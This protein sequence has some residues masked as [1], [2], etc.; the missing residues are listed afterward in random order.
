MRIAS[1]CW[2]LLAALAGPAAGQQAPVMVEFRLAEPLY[3]SLFTPAELARLQQSAAQLLASFLKARLPVL[4]LRAAGPADYRL[5]VTLDR[6]GGSSA[7]PLQS[8]R[9][10]YAQIVGPDSA[11]R[12]TWFGLFRRASLTGEGFGSTGGLPLDR[13]FLE[14]IRLAVAD[15]DVDGLVRDHLS[16]VPLTSLGRIWAPPPGTFGWVAALD[17]QRTCLARGTGLRVVVLLPNAF[18]PEPVSQTYQARVESDFDAEHVFGGSVPPEFAGLKRAVF[19]RPEPLQQFGLDEM[20]GEAR[21]RVAAVY[22]ANFQLDAGV[23][24]RLPEPAEAESGVGGG[25]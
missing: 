12:P 19:A 17:R 1:A 20:R 14:K 7:N 6:R 21:A 13:L 5:R 8:D 2:L 25:A 22:L 24:D 11:T 10:F 3:A 4:D 9:G 16:R 23:C 15:A 18:V